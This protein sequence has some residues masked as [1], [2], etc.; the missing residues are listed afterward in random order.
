MARWACKNA[1]SHSQP[2]KAGGPLH[3]NWVISFLVSKGRAAASKASRAGFLVPAGIKR[4]QLEDPG[5]YLWAGSC[6]IFNTIFFVLKQRVGSLMPTSLKRKIFGLKDLFFC[7]HFSFLDSSPPPPHFM[8]TILLEVTTNFKT[9]LYTKGICLDIDVKCPHIH[10]H[11][12][13]P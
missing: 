11:T 10:T 9:Y 7:F 8:H 3:L 1:S 5:S 4:W 6:R 13:T 2:G 12:H